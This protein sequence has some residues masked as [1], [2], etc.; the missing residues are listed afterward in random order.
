M[1]GHMRDYSSRFVSAVVNMMQGRLFP[2]YCGYQNLP[3]ILSSHMLLW[4]PLFL[5]ISFYPFKQGPFFSTD[6]H[7]AL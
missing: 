6:N 3:T 4:G 2:A 5:C 7:R 1:Q